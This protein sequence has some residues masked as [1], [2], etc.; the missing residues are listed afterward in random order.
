VGNTFRSQRRAGRR[1]HALESDGCVGR[2]DAFCLDHDSE[3]YTMAE[4]CRIYGIARKTGYQWVKRYEAEGLGGS[5]DRR[6]YGPGKYVT[7]GT[8]HV[9][10]TF[11]PERGQ[12]EGSMPW[13]VTDVLD[14]RTRFVL[15]YES[16]SFTMAELCRIYGIARKT[17]Y[18]N[19]P[20]IGPRPGGP[21]AKPSP[22]RQG[23]ET[24]RQDCGALEARHYLHSGCRASGVR[25]ISRTRYPSPSESV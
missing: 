11:R 17:G 3:Q 18:G 1:E 16:G 24:D 5:P 15:E 2:A 6:W 13:K 4:L 19:E 12:V 7:E 8:G 14:E 23:W 9:G 21:T 25:T 22:A 10:N 20:Q